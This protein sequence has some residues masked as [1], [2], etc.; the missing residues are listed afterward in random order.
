MN[1]CAK[2]ESVKYFPIFGAKIQILIFG[3]KLRFS[4]YCVK[5]TRVSYGYEDLYYMC[6]HFRMLTGD[7]MMSDGSAILRGIHLQGDRRRYLAQIGY[8]PQFDSIIDVMTGREMLTLFARLRGMQPSQIKEEVN[9]W[10]E[11]VGTFSKENSVPEINFLFG[12]VNFMLGFLGW[13]S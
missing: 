1:F 6:S 10:I 11:E 8:C 13:K 5:A 7:E 12:E 2:N 4:E 3:T 9:Y